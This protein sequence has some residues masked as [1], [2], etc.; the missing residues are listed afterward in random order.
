M[1]VVGSAGAHDVVN[2]V[3]IHY[4]LSFL[5]DA[6]HNHLHALLK[7]AAILSAHHKVGKV[8]LEDF[9]IL[10]AVGHFA[11]ADALGKA[12]DNGCLAHA[13]V[14]H[15]QRIVLF[16]AAKHLDGACKLVF[17]PDERIVLSA[18]ELYALHVVEPSVFFRVGIIKYRTEANSMIVWLILLV[19]VIGEV[20]FVIISYVFVIV[21]GRD[22]GDISVSIESLVLVKEVYVTFILI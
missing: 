9:S 18:V 15:M 8:E 11:L 16:L 7:I 4:A 6:I 12:I 22:F 10:Q 14:A 21:G 2:L 19:V 20:V 13:R 3:D 5:A 17:A 1:A